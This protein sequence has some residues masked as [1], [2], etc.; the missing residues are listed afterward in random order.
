M[1]GNRHQPDFLSPSSEEELETTEQEKARRDSAGPEDSAPPS[2]PSF[3]DL[4]LD[5]D[6]AE[7]RPPAILASLCDPQASI[8][9]LLEYRFGEAYLKQWLANPDA[10]EQIGRQLAF[11]VAQIDELVNEQLNAVLHHPRFQ[12]LEA[13]WRGVKYIVEQAA[14]APDAGIKVRLLSITWKEVCRDVTDAQEWDQSNLFKKIYEDEFGMP[15]GEPY[16]I[17][18]GDYEI[19]PAPTREHPYRDIDVLES[20]AEI[21]A[22]SFCPIICGADPSMFGVDDFGTLEQTKDLGAGFREKEFANWNALRSQ[23]SA[24]YVGLALPRVL[25][26]PKY[27]LEIGDGLIFREDTSDPSGKDLLWGNAAYAYAEVLLRCF[28][29]YSWLADIRGTER[30]VEGGGLVTGLPVHYFDTDKKGVAP[31]CSTD[32]VITDQREAELTALG[33]LPLCHCHDT[34]Y[35]AF[36]SSASIQQ[37]KFYGKESTATINAKI[38]SMIQYVLCS[39]RFAHYLKVIARDMVGSVADATELQ[40]LLYRWAVQYV[41]EPDA[42]PESKAMRPLRDVQV[43]VSEDPGNPGSYICIFNLWPHYQLDDL[44]ASLHLRTTVSRSDN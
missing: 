13:S 38:S 22:A 34:E 35:S 14:R 5:K 6:A 20:L 31:K 32:V 12:K 26:R 29:R 25:M 11:D 18:I 17:I 39:S 21:G 10:S 7:G 9:Q 44:A 24:R 42:K 27:D 1:T 37:P 3:F 15:G 40:T 4:V 30:D 23:D 8:R 33:F 36:Y 19:H 28:A 41:S 16:G 43:T 2:P